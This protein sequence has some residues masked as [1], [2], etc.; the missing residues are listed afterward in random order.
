MANW[1]EA[2]HPRDDIGRFTDKGGGSSTKTKE[3]YEEKMQRRAEI[4]FPNTEEKKTINSNFDYKNIGLGNFNNENLSREDI[5]FPTMKKNKYIENLN[6]TD[7]I[8]RYQNNTLETFKQNL[9]NKSLEVAPTWNSSYNAKFSDSELKKAREFIHGAEDFGAEAYKP[10]PNDVWTIGYG[11]TGLVDGKPIT[12]GMK[13]TK[14]K[15]EELYR[16][17]F[18]KHIVGLKNIEVPL[19][20]NQKIALASFAYNNGPG[21]LNKDSSVVKKLNSGDFKGASDKMG[22]YIKQTNKKTGKREVLKGLINRRAKEKNLFY[23][24][25]EE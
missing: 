9:R 3:S 4:L 14:E 25:D 17:D 23:T 19:T 12:P 15:A 6:E 8:K 18:E 2:D 24:P 20:T 5:L 1:N 16:K 10:T 21:V 7:T 13:I 11:H 22:E